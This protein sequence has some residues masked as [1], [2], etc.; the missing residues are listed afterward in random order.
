[1]QRYVNT[2][3]KINKTKYSH[4]K[5]KIHLKCNAA[6]HTQNNKIHCI[7]NLK[8]KCNAALHKKRSREAGI[9]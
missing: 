8:H 4:N 6:L 7:I 3:A 2:G 1:M 9:S 5:D